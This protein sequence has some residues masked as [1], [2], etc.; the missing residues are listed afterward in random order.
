MSPSQAIS[1][2]VFSET[3][4][5]G[6]K[7]LERLFLQGMPH[8]KDANRVTI[9]MPAGRTWY[10]DYLVQKGRTQAAPRSIDE[11]RRRKEAA[12]AEMSEL[13]LAKA[14]QELVVV[15]D[16]R[17]AV[18]EAFGRV[19][20]KILN[21]PPRLAGVVVGV[22]TKPEALARIEPLVLEILAELHAA[23]DVPTEPDDDE[24]TPDSAA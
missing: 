11:A 14:R 15:E 20:A 7:Q 17:T 5:V 21:L 2:R 16:F 22:N 12:E 6:E 9:P 18:A 4:G 1:K 10:Y 13:E 19:R 23:D 3:F 8:K 24:S